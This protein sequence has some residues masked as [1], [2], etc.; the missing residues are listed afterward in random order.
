M[1][2]PLAP[3]VGGEGRGEGAQANPASEVEV[4]PF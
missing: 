1:M 3:G 4:P 2:P